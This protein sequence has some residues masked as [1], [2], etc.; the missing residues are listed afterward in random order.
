MIPGLA[1][2]L[3]AG[4][5]YT[6]KILGDWEEELLKTVPKRDQVAEILQVIRDG[7][8]NPDNRLSQHDLGRLIQ[9]LLRMAEEMK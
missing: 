7:Q 1:G 3:F 2:S 9:G 8:E 6:S 5:L 4:R